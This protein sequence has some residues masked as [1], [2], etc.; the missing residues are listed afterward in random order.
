MSNKEIALAYCQRTLSLKATIESAFLEL[1]ERLM[2]IRD[3]KLF[4][5]QFETF[6]LYCD[7]MKMSGAVVNKLINIYQKFILQYAMDESRLLEA[8]GWSQLAEI[9]PY[10][11]DRDD[12]EDLVDKA[13]VLSRKDLRDY[14]KE[15]KTGVDQQKC[16][17]GDTYDIRCCKTCGLKIKII[18]DE[19]STQA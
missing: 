8:G 13:K 17:H 7:E 18:K 4:V 15:R 16:K 9:L 3:E 14:L 1:G 2:K 12:A 19:Q 5:G 11:K 10:I 6:E